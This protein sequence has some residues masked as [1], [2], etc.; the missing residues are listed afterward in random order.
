MSEITLKEAYKNYFKIGVAVNPNTLEK[1]GDLIKKHFNSLTPENHMKPEELQP[2][3]G[4]FTFEKADK[5]VAFAKENDMELRGHT[6]VWHNQTPEWMFKD[7]DKEASRE[8]ALKHMKEHIEAVLEHYSKEPFYAWDVI[9]EVIADEGDELLR[10]SPW[11]SIIGDDYVE[12]A[13]EF[14]HAA[15]PNMP[16]YYNDYNESHPEKREKIYK[17]VKGL[18]DKGIPIHGV[19]LQAHWGLEDPSLDNIREAIEKYASLGLKLH[20]TE[21]D[22]SVFNFEDR[23]TDLSKPTEEMMKK[24]AERYDAFFKLFREYS[25]HIESVTLWAASDR[26][27]WLNDFPVRG[28]KN[29]PMLFDTENQPKESFLRVTSFN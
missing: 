20:I 11:R 8:V 23:R 22:V 12:K 3:E 1:D 26:Y 7:G 17:L 13:F 5:I 27:N 9:N 24:Q 18:K 15:D 28:R 4:E 14:A 21:M 25:E 6:L 10:E 2:K 16:L 29:W 19:G